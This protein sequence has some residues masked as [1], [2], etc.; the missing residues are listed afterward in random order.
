[1]SKPIL[2]SEFLAACQLFAVAGWR[3]SH[4]ASQSFCSISPLKSEASGTFPVP[5]SFEFLLA[6]LRNSRPL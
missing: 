6:R 5:D 4:S 3:L 2:R 1:M